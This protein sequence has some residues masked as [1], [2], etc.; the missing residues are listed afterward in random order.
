MFEKI[1]KQQTTQK[2]P[3]YW[4]EVEPEKANIL[5]QSLF[6]FC[7][8]RILT[9]FVLFFETC[10]VSV[11]FRFL[12]CTRKFTKVWKKLKKNNKQHKNACLIETISN[13]LKI[14][15]TFFVLFMKHTQ[16]LLCFKRTLTIS[17]YCFLKHYIFCI[18]SVFWSV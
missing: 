14:T 6:L 9:F 17:V 18:V 2:M 8:L 12:K 7:F 4:N 15:C 3:V 1:K 10:T 11:L 16:F 5:W 13:P